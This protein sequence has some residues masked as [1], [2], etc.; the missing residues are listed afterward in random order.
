MYYARCFWQAQSKRKKGFFLYKLNCVRAHF[1]PSS[2]GGLV[3][4]VRTDSE[5][6]KQEG[7]GMQLSVCCYT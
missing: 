4:A 6:Q 5:F 7:S 2:T 3:E 1:M